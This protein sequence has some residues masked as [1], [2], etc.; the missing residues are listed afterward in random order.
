[1]LRRL[2]HCYCQH[3]ALKWVRWCYRD[4]RGC[5]AWTNKHHNGGDSR[6]MERVENSFLPFFA[7][8]TALHWSQKTKDRNNLLLIS[9]VIDKQGILHSFSFIYV[10]TTMHHQTKKNSA[11]CLWCRSERKYNWGAEWWKTGRVPPS[12]FFLKTASPS[13]NQTS[14]NPLLFQPH[15]APK[16]P[17]SSP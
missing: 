17:V 9:S 8:I 5:W 16:S 12:L 15:A 6:E 3:C 11:E 13:A 1:M 14:S 10:S 4:S 2:I 7:I